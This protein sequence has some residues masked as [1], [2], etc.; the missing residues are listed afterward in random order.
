[1]LL[2]NLEK[3]TNKYIS[4]LQEFNQG[5]KRHQM[6]KCRTKIGNLKI[7]KVIKVLYR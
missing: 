1:V 7:N 4:S 2:C 5:V 3:V 6:A